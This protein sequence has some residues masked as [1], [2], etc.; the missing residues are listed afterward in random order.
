M[1]TLNTKDL[2]KIF[3]INVRNFETLGISIYAMNIKSDIALFLAIRLGNIKIAQLFMVHKLAVAIISEHR[4]CV[5]IVDI[6]AAFFVKLCLIVGV[7]NIK[8]L[9]KLYSIFFR[10]SEHDF[11]S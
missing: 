5:L 1:Y 2:K 9:K 4:L 7:L 11:N 3:V 10:Y 8:N 6:S